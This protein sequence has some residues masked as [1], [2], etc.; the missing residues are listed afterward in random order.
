MANSTTDVKLAVLWGGWSDEREISHASASACAKA[1]GEAGFEDVTM[2]D[3]AD[4]G[5][6]TK[7]SGGGYDVAFIAMHG[8]Y[9]EDGSI[10]G[11]CEVLHLPYTFSG[12]LASA[13]ASDKDISK[14]IYEKAG[15][16]TPKGVA[17]ARGESY[18]VDELLGYLG[19]PV[20][21]KPAVNGSSY[22]VTKVYEKDQLI[23][24]V[25]LALESSEH[26]LV[27]E[28]IAG[29]EITVPVL[30][31]AEAEALPIVEIV[32]GADFYDL[33]VK[34]EPTEL[35]HVI[36][37]RLSDEIYNVAAGYAVKAHQAL[38]CAGAS[39]SDFIVTDEGV[40]VILETN[41]IPGMTESSLLPDSAAHAGITFPELC[42]RF[43]ELA[44]ETD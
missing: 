13:M 27:E 39:R 18:D 41:T 44:L 30:G 33:K 1:L 19:L 38:G 17:I 6:F 15:I 40:P 21:V 2:L 37:A 14:I 43:V 28:F 8:A 35:H 7:I 3:V 25:N 22:G 29:T 26:A 12:V 23:D 9:G 11:L 4:E 32:T 31:N 5:F 20:F 24:A 36:P 10:Q 34:Y 42:R 16:P